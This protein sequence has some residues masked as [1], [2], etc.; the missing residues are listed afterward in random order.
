MAAKGKLATLVAELDARMENAALVSGQRLVEA[1]LTQEF[2]IS[3]ALLREA[4]RHL[5]AEGAIEMVPN[6]G[7]EVR[8]LTKCEALELFEIRTELEVLAA[9]RAAS[10]MGTPGVA[11][12]FEASV[13]PLLSGP[14]LSGAMEYISENEAF[15]RAIFVA[16][17]NETLLDLARKL[18]L[19]QIM[20]QL[21]AAMTPE[22]LAL[23]QREHRAVATAIRREDPAMAEAEIRQHL[24]RA[25]QFV[26]Q[27]PERMFRPEAERSAKDNGESAA[28]RPLFPGPQPKPTRV[29]SALRDQEEY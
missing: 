23:S 22:M 15:H 16:A 19:S 18:R 27:A 25:T 11:Q 24:D 1:D 9:R 17:G 4:F 10:R 13:T 3:R 26:Y 28:K 21:R 5:A 7:A 6:R 29:S 20:S 8:R 12:V 14:Q 2:G